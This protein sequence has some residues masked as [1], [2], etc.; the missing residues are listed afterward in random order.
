[1]RKYIEIVET[2]ENHLNQKYGRDKEEIKVCLRE[3]YQEY[4]TEIST[5]FLKDLLSIDLTNRQKTYLIKNLLKF[6][7]LTT[8]RRMRFF[9]DWFNQSGHVDV[10]DYR[11][12]KDGNVFIKNSEEIRIGNFTKQ[13]VGEVLYFLKGF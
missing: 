8:E 2:L 11:V 5:K 12:D 13:I 6:A 4:K 3:L 10:I 7:G 1:M 9:S